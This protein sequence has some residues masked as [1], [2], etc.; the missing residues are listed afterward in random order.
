MVRRAVRR[1]TRPRDELGRPQPF[2]SSGEPPNDA[3][4]LEPRAALVEA[5]RLLRDGKPFAA[6]E[7]LEAV[8]KATDGAERGLWRGLAQLAVGVTHA[9]RGNP[10]G[11]TALLQRAAT[12]L[13]P[14]DATAPYDVDVSGLRAWCLTAAADPELAGSPPAL[15]DYAA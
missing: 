5:T 3:P 2:G 10:T 8:W 4:A 15:V 11:A 1:N 6:H 14:Y 9:L 7:I 12:T 13:E